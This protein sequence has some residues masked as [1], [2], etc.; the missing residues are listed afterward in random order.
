MKTLI[1]GLFLLTMLAQSF[2][3]QQ[4]PQPP[5]E[6]IKTAASHTPEQ[7][8]HQPLKHEM[9]LDGKQEGRFLGGTI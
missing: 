5:T 7:R 9:G 1:I 2:Y 8:S 6:T 4:A 3:A